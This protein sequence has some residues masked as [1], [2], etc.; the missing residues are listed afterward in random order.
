MATFSKRISF[1]NQFDKQIGADNFNLNL[2][3]LRNLANLNGVTT[4]SL[5]EYFKKCE[6]ERK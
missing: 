1:L 2:V 5:L 6:E 4:I 3:R